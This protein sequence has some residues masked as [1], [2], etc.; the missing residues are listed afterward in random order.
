MVLGEAIID[1]YTFVDVMNISSKSPTLST[2]YLYHEDYTGG[3]LA[4]AKNLGAL[5]C[6][7]NVFYPS[8]MS[9]SDKNFN[10]ELKNKSENRVTFTPLN[11]KQWN[12]PIK[13]R[14][15]TEW[16]ESIFANG[17]NPQVKI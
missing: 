3:S 8:G 15:L 4:I 16:L 2:K 6:K 10:F 1:R 11:L 17:I 9:E 14:F 12:I 7:A 5:G 13:N